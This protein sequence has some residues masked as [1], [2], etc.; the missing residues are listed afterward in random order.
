MTHV[1]V[2]VNP[3]KE[4]LVESSGKNNEPIQSQPERSSTAL[5][6]SQLVW[7]MDICLLLVHVR[8]MQSLSETLSSPEAVESA[9]QAG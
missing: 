9:T 3:S 2:Q 6:F 5:G 1:D 8:M 7:W 4:E